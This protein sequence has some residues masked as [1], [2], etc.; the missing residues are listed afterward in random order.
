MKKKKKKT[1]TTT[2]LRWNSTVEIIYTV[3]DLLPIY[4]REQRA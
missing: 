4:F 2:T 3:S 1:T